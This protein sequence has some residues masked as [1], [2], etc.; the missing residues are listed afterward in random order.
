MSF[1]QCSVCE[2]TVD[3][4]KAYCPECGSAMDEEEKRTS[5]SE[6]DQLMKTQNINS[7]THF[8]LM[9]QFKLSSVFK[10]PQAA[11][12]DQNLEKNKEAAAAKATAANAPP[13]EKTPDQKFAAAGAANAARGTVGGQIENKPAGDNTSTSNTKIYIIIGAA[14]FFLA[15]FVISIVLGLLYWFYPR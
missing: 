9:E 6:F 14:T 10:P 8:R 11:E 4:A 1:I 13:P 7:T 2:A 5:F 3:A 12:A 15:L